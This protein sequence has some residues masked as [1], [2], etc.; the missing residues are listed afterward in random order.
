VY[1]RTIYIVVSVL[2]LLASA[3]CEEGLSAT[4]APAATAA[5][6]SV[7][8]VEPTLVPTPTQVTP[9]ATQ[10]VATPT[11][12]PLTATV[13]AS[14][15]SV[16]IATTIAPTATPV[17]I[18]AP[19]PTATPDPYVVAVD[20][21][22]SYDN[23]IFQ[24]NYSQLRGKSQDGVIKL[25]GY[26]AIDLELVKRVLI[27]V[28]FLGHDVDAANWTLDL[29]HEHMARDGVYDP[30]DFVSVQDAIVLTHY[31]QSDGMVTLADGSE[32]DRQ[33]HLTATESART[34]AIA[35]ADIW[36]WLA[37]PE[38]SLIGDGPEWFQRTYPDK[39]AEFSRFACACPYTTSASADPRFSLNPVFDGDSLV[40]GVAGN[41]SSNYDAYKQFNIERDSWLRLIEITPTDEAQKLE[42]LASGD[43]FGYEL[44]T[45]APGFVTGVFN[46]FNYQLITVERIDFLIRHKSEYISSLEPRTRAFTDDIGDLEIA[47]MFQRFDKSDMYGLTQVKH[48]GAFRIFDLVDPRYGNRIRFPTP[49]DQDVLIYIKGTTWRVSEFSQGKFSYQPETFGGLK[50]VNSSA[51]PDGD[52]TDNRTYT[53]YHSGT[54][55]SA[56]EPQLI[57]NESFTYPFWDPQQSAEFLEQR[58]GVQ[59][60]QKT[61]GVYYLLEP[62]KLDEGMYWTKVF[63]N[64]DQMPIP[65]SPEPLTDSEPPTLTGL[66]ISAQP[67]LT[68]DGSQTI[69]FTLE[70]SDDLSGMN[71]SSQAIDVCTKHEDQDQSLCV[72]AHEMNR[73]GGT[74][75]DGTYKT[76]RTLPQ[77]SPTGRWIIDQ[78]TLMD[79]VGNMSNYFYDDLVELGFEAEFQVAS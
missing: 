66:S 78:I 43:Q 58:G 76:E 55:L 26:A 68:S 2:F 54:V 24:S 52:L 29:Y 44:Q 9:T 70:V 30:T 8:I 15:T 36:G 6:T 14:A 50:V 60:D 13:R 7:P 27:A 75:L 65:E 33:D 12:T 11:R 41:I 59:I 23:N 34:T 51:H 16:P 35:G 79:N 72:Q 69:Q 22:Q 38:D 17:P 46:I 47:L 37:N 10:I 25:A 77:F 5:P 62:A 61:H 48:S 20:Q 3:A 57:P 42:D 73:T 53:T 40:S 39:E 45:N 19:V 74:A 63:D 71:R 1:K 32:V 49:N 21:L 56:G 64:R 67:L 28:N 4:Q 18:M 31:M